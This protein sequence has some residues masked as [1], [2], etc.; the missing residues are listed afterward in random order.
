MS[1]FRP[2][3]SDESNLFTIR[4]VIDWTVNLTNAHIIAGGSNITPTTNL[5]K[6][7]TANNLPENFVIYVS[8]NIF[9][10]HYGKEFTTC[11]SVSIQP[12]LKAITNLTSGTTAGDAPTPVIFW[13]NIINYAKIPQVINSSNYNFA[14]AFKDGDKALITPEATGA[15][16]PLSGFDLVI[17]GPVKLGVTTGNSNKG[18]AVGSGNDATSAYTFM[19]VG[20]GTGNP[21]ATGLTLNGGL[22]GVPDTVSSTSLAISVETFVTFID[23]SNAATI[24]LA[25]G[26]NG[27]IKHLLCTVG[28]GSADMTLANTNLNG[29]TTSIVFN[30]AG[31]T[32]T[33]IYDSTTGKW[34]VLSSYGA[35]IS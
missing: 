24:T 25:A 2:L 10:V 32:A 18:W 15:N 7:P 31:E 11:P 13:N 8:G 28:T 9:Y 1:I 20:V 23:A 30:A 26:T 33:L 27:Q 14:F 17:T 19:N 29:V 6:T 34:S 5:L 4:C 3:N 16:G 22:V 12:R 21:T 35:T